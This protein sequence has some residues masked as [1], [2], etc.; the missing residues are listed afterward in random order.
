L[1][2]DKEIEERKGKGESEK[3]KSYEWGKN[4]VSACTTLVFEGVLPV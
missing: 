1:E 4:M 2:T 3:V